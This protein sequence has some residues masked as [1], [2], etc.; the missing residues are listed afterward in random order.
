MTFTAPLAHIPNPDDRLKQ[1]VWLLDELQTAELDQLLLGSLGDAYP[2]VRQRAA[3]ELVDRMSA[4]S[5][6]WLRALA[7]G[8]RPPGA[9]EWCPPA[10]LEVRQAAILALRGDDTPE[11]LATLASLRDAPESDLRY[12]ALITLFELG[13]PDE[14]LLP[15]VKT[16]LNDP[17]AEV[18]VVAAQATAA[19]Q[20]LALIPQLVSRRQSLRHDLR[21]QFTLAL[22]EVLPAGEDEHV[23]ELMDELTAGVSDE[24]TSSACAS[25]LVALALR[26]QRVPRAQE[27]LKGVLERWLLHPLLKVEAAAQLAR[28]GDVQGLNFLNKSFDSRRKDARGYAIDVAGRFKLEPLYGRVARVA[29]DASDYHADTALLALANYA[30]PEARELLSELVDHHATQELRDI[31]H[32]ALSAPPDTLKTFMGME[33]DHAI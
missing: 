20:W 22:A 33:S 12:Q 28:L 27:A 32:Q 9:P 1:L 4:R 31:A 17:D 6:Q 25:A 26:H 24:K 2:P 13:A 8:S 3:R 7:E 16:G 21:L 15:V 10:T 11:T 5:A 23:E 18:A 19:R 30:T 14:V 29:Q